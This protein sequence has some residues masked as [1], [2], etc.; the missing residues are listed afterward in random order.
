MD[1]RFKALT[2]GL[3]VIS[4]MAVG[5]IAHAGGISHAV[6][7]GGTPATAASPV[8]ATVH[9]AD[10][11]TPGDTADPAA[12]NDVAGIG[13]TAD[14]QK[15]APDVGTADTDSIQ[16]GSQSGADTPDA[17]AGSEMPGNDG[18]GGHADEV[19]GTADATAQDV[20]AN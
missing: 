1:A 13:D 2:A 20:A 9:A 6:N 18:P 10:P 19:G 3:A 7:S 15:D 5:G 16:Q 14:T 4:A 17:P 8:T 11:T 12:A